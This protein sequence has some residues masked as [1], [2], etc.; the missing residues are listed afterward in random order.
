MDQGGGSDLRPPLRAATCRHGCGRSR[1][2][3]VPFLLWADNREPSEH[4][5]RDDDMANQGASQGNGR[6]LLQPWSSRIRTQPTAAEETP[7]SRL[8]IQAPMVRCG[9]GCHGHVIGP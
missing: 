1:K 7:S 9:S 3:L 4:I 8:S 2:A 6:P 5:S